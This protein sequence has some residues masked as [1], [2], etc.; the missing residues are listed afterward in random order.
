MEEKKADTIFHYTSFE[1]LQ[2]I[3][4]NKTIRLNCLRNVDDDEEATTTDFGPQKDYFFVSCWTKNSVESI[5]MWTMYVESDF[6]VRIE[7]P[8]QF[9]VLDL[10]KKG[11]VTNHLNP[12]AVCYPIHRGTGRGS[13]FL[14][15]VVYRE[16]PKSTVTRSLRGIFNDDYIK[17][18]GLLKR[19][20]WQFQEEVRFILQAVPQKYIRTV[21]RECSEYQAFAEVIINNDASDIEYID[22]PFDEDWLSDTNLMLGPSTTP[23][24]EIELRKYV[25][26]MVPGYRGEITRSKHWIKR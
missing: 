1:T 11:Q 15:E 20:G 16:E 24:H 7:L 13:E 5:P 19:N 23:D 8:K 26:R 6:A 14:S 25:N 22:L 4:E 21:R 10:N 12:D 2:K 9:L 3:V 17:N 18:I